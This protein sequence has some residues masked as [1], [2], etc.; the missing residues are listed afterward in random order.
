MMVIFAGAVAVGAA[1]LSPAPR[2]ARGCLRMDAGEMP[3]PPRIQVAGARPLTTSDGKR[4]GLSLSVLKSIDEVPRDAWDACASNQGQANPFVL[5]AYLHALEVSKS[6]AP[7]EGWMPHHLVAHD[8]ASG[9]LVGAIPLYLKSHSYGEYVFDHSWARAYRSTSMDLSN[10]GYYPKLQACIPFTPVTGARLLVANCDG[11]HGEAG[12]EERRATIRRVLARGLVALSERLGVSSVHVTFGTRGADGAALS[13][14]GFLPRLGVQYMWRNEGYTSFEDYLS[15]L[16]Q[17]RRKA[18]RQE[19]RKVADAGVVVRRLRGREILPEHWDALYRFYFA[20]VEE[21]WGRGYLKR[22]FFD[23]FGAD[24]EMAQRTLLVL[25]TEPES[26]EIIAGALNLLGD[27]CVYGR[28]WGCDKRYD[29]LHFEMCYYQAIEA[30]IELGLPRVEAGAQGDHKLARG[31]LPSLTY[32]WHHLRH[33]GFRKSVKS[34]LR[35]EIEQTYVSV[36]T[37]ATRK[38][39]FKGE[40]HAHLQRQGLRLEGKRVLV[41]EPV[42]SAPPAQQSPVP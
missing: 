29:S 41:G 13:T 17:R 27:D 28:L 35:K 24:E 33:E 31:Y 32:S 3:L 18:V 36:A 23:S 11:S 37:L 19:R 20:T 6:V 14:A 40:P 7:E 16:K 15:R 34:F 9:E 25:A 4:H 30:A 1:L 5:W 2:H 12:A 38:N 21:K 42:D 22:G 26:G 10:G 8:T 39:P